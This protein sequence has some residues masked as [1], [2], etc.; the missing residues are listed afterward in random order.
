MRGILEYA[1]QVSLP[2]QQESLNPNHDP[3][4]QGLGTARSLP[5]AAKRAAVGKENGASLLA[6]GHIIGAPRPCPVG[7]A[8][9]LVPA[10]PQGVRQP[11]PRALYVACQ[12]TCSLNSPYVTLPRP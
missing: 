4:S 5:G 6:A 8:P 9:P 7:F 1:F 11:W 2:F 10:T 12:L 3:W